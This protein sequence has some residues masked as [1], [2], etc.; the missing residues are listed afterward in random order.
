MGP[1]N[2]TSSRSP[3]GPTLL[4]AE[5][6]VLAGAGR[7]MRRWTPARKEETAPTDPPDRYGPAHA[8][9]GDPTNLASGCDAGVP[10]VGK[11]R[12]AP[13]CLSGQVL[14]LVDGRMTREGCLP[15]VPDKGMSGQAQV[16]RPLAGGNIACTSPG[17]VSTVR[18]GGI[19]NVRT[20]RLRSCL[21]QTTVHLVRPGTCHRSMAQVR[22]LARWFSDS[23]C[24]AC[25][26]LHRNH[27]LERGAT[28]GEA[29][30]GL[31]GSRGGVSPSSG[32]PRGESVTV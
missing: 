7:P 17:L 20:P 31:A 24:P 21:I 10:M 13:C 26:A 28:P 3:A 8:R 32:A 9:A 12:S 18:A 19:V 11:A 4:Q 30:V 15:P 29:A 5:I 23:R 16:Y 6:E 22:I 14:L 25:P 2:R 1:S 27:P